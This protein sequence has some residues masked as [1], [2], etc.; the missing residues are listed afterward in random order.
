MV[1]QNL[2][3]LLA[4]DSREAELESNKTESSD[5]ENKHAPTRPMTQ[6]QTKQDAKVGAT[7]YLQEAV[8]SMSA[9]VTEWL[10]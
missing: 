6:S 9:Y 3:L 2:L 5:S 7:K 8:T 1:H 10:G 4:H